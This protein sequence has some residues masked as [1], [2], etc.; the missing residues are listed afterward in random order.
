M[1][2]R[3]PPAFR[4]A[5]LR[6]L[7]HPVPPQTSAFLTVGPPLTCRTTACV[8]VSTFRACEMRP[9]WAPSMPRGGGV[10]PGGVNRPPGACR[11][12]AT[13]P[14]PRFC[15]PPAGAFLTRRQRGFT[16][17]RPSG[18]LLACRP[19]VEQ[20]LLGFYLE[21]RTP[22]LPATHVQAETGHRTRTRDYPD[23]GDTAD[24]L[25]KSIHSTHAT[26]CRTCTQKVPSCWYDWDL[27]QASS[28]Q[29]RR[30]FRFFD[31]DLDAPRNETRRLAAVKSPGD[32]APG[33]CACG[34]HF[35]P[36]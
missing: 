24:P 33:P 13:R 17:V 2:S 10:H 6:F 22:P 25:S 16:G 20:G 26:S 5:G 29:L 3:F 32:P 31:H 7:S 9:G 30:H 36:S 11:L 18:L 19:W 14:S 35:V 8:G 4:P 21:L 23:I 12:A 28:L 34:M 27:R 15:I 1:L